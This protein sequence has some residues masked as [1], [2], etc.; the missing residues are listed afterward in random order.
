MTGITRRPRRGDGG[1]VAECV[2]RPQHATRFAGRDTVTSAILLVLGG[3]VFGMLG[4]L[5]T[6][7][8]FRDIERPRR[9][10][11]EDPTVADAMASTGLR[12]ARGGTTMWRAWVGF[13]FSHGLGLM[14]FAACTIALGLSLD[15][16]RVPHGLLLLPP[17]VGGVYAFLAARYWF[18]VPALGTA[19]GTLCFAVAW[20]L[21]RLPSH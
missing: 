19:L 2:R 16:V 7:L 1:T 12:I 15:S 4:L 21:Y 6:W 18:R 11:P 3:A 8:T 10:A 14:V 13:N 17:A 20:A 5:H 9:L